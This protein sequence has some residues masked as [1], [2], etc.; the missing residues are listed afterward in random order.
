MTNLDELLLKGRTGSAILFCG[1]G[2]TADCLNFNDTNGLGVTSHL[3][4]IMNSELDEK[5]KTTGYRDI[6]NAAKAYKKAFGEYQ[7]KNTLVN[8]FTLSNVSSSI[9]NIIKYPW[10]KIYTTNF[11]NGLE[12]AHQYIHKKCCSFN[13][14]DEEEGVY[15]D[16]CT[17]I[18]HLHGYVKS[19]DQYNFEK[20]CVLDLDSYRNITALQKWLNTLRYDI[21][22]ASVV[23]FIGF[24]A[25]DFHLDQVFYNVSNLKSKAFFI[26]PVSQNQN[27]DEQII[28]EDFGHPV[29]IGREEFSLVLDRVIKKEKINELSLN[30]FEK[31]KAIPS[32]KSVPEVKDIEELFIWGNV[33]WNQIKRDNEVL[34]SDYHVLRS[35]IEFIYESLKSKGEVFFIYGDICEGKTLIVNGLSN[36][37]VGEREVF[38][39]KHA[40]YDLLQEASSIISHYKGATIII[41]NCFTLQEENLLSI[42]REVSASDSSLLL[43]ARSISSDAETVKHKKLKKISNFSEMKVGKLDEEETNSLI[44]LLNQIAGWRYFEGLSYTEKKDFILKKCSGYIPNVLLKLLQSKY[45]QKKYK[46]EYNKISY[47]NDHEKHMVISSL[48]ISSLG[49]DPS[50]SFMCD[51]FEEDFSSIIKK[52]P[53]SKIIGIKEGRIQ[54]PPSIGARNLLNSI[55]EDKDI[56]NSNIKLLTNLSEKRS[57][58]DF[59]KHIFTFLMRYSIICTIVQNPTEI[60]RFFDH[61]S[62]IQT[63]L[64]MPLFWLQWHMAMNAQERWNDAEKYIEMSYKAAE[65]YEKSMG[66]QYNRKQIDDRYA[67]FLANRV[68]LGRRQSDE[69]FRDL[70]KAIENTGKI[71]NDAEVSH[72]PY[73]T[74]KDVMN[75]YEGKSHLVQENL[76]R[77]LLEGIEGIINLADKRLHLIPDGYQTDHAKTALE[78]TKL[79]LHAVRSDH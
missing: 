71:L 65:G 79:I 3:L 60:N 19:W 24:S 11:D 23:V 25:S 10:A 14:L 13:N 50:I 46:E 64:K 34:K 36:R 48:L 62:K 53:S 32:S 16:N 78:S 73:E 67:K 12:I 8:R 9:C 15:K 28:Q 20:S 1:A 52:I 37:I 57:T 68:I 56:V 54:T 55:I 17:P 69:I 2:L 42:V 7:L 27:P 29:N 72:H 66:R 51:V 33:N 43:T 21:E 59:E 30:S 45:V 61:I 41:E 47:L 49:Y 76:R 35:K 6:K 77:V 22:R 40:Y 18:I 5:G 75:A 44:N 63:F 39:L 31:F 70:K 74:I 38:I 58:S 4:N 26:N